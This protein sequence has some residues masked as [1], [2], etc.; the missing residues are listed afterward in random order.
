MNYYLIG[1]EGMPK[2][3]ESCGEPLKYFKKNLYPDAFKKLYQEHFETFDAIENGYNSVIDKDQ[4]LV[5][6]AD[7]L[8]AHAVELLNGCH[9]K[10]ARERMQMDLN[11]TMAV[12][13]LPMVLE[14]KGNSSKPLSEKLLDSWKKEFPKS[15]LQAAD[16]EYIEK[17]FHKKF[18]YITTAVCQSFGKSD[19]CHELTVLR[20]YRD[21]YLAS[22]PN[23]KE[24]IEKYYD[25]APTIVKHIDQRADAKE[26]YRSIWEEYLSPCI[27][28]IESGQ[29]ETC[30]KR[31]EEM[32]YTLRD[33]YFIQ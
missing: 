8:T 21:N 24:L 17:G 26:I 23:G 6:M 25:V 5:N 33:K 18:C 19:D 10:N 16:F 22:L 28:L 31:Y 32:V 13:A 20:D 27:S 4:F 14:Y 2:L 7:A 9:R 30:R 15:N 1:I 12:F 11:M 29:M 3:L